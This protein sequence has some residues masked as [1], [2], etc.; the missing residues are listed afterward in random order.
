MGTE[1]ML[2]EMYWCVVLIAGNDYLND[3]KKKNV[4]FVYKVIYAYISLTE[5]ILLP[6]LLP[7]F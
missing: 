7:N 2:K 6:K 3:K 1:N 5:R 4:F